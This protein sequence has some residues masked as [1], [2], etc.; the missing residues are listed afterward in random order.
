MPTWLI[1]LQLA[2]QAA[3]EIA[4]MIDVNNA[5]TE[6]PEQ[7]ATLIAARDKAIAAYDAAS[8]TA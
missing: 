2:L 6:T 1:V 3:P 5:P 8:K 4:S 7:M